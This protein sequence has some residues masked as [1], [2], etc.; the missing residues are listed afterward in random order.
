M[1]GTSS[2]TSSREHKSFNI[3]KGILQLLSTTIFE[4]NKDYEFYTKEY[5]IVSCIFSLNIYFFN[6]LILGLLSHLGFFHLKLIPSINF[7]YMFPF[8]IFL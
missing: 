1:V 4:L 2:I 7:C 3:I 8:T 6:I 5:K